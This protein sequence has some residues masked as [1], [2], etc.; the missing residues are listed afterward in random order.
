M[1]IVNICISILFVVL[2]FWQVQVHLPY[3][4]CQ[5]EHTNLFIGDWDA[6]LASL[7]QMG[8]VVKWV[9]T[10]G[11]QFF[12]KPVWGVLMFLLPVWGLF[13]ITACVLR[14]KGKSEGLWIPL[15]AWLAVAQLFSL[16]DFNFYWWG[17]MAL[18]LALGILWVWSF[19]KPTWVRDVLFIV[20]IPFI[21]WWLGSVVLVYVLAGIGLFSQKKRWWQT[22]LLPFMVYV[23]SIALIYW[24]SGCP[25]L[26]AAVSPSMYF[27]ALLDLSFYHLGAWGIAILVWG[28]CRFLPVI[29]KKALVVSIGVIGWALPVYGLLQYG[30]AFRNQS[31]IDLWRLNH[32]AYTENWDGILQFLAGKPMNNYLFMNY[33]NMALAEKGEL[34]NLAFNYS[35]RGMN[36]LMVDANSTGSIRM[37]ASDI[38]YMVGCVAE[39]QQHTFE[40]QVTFPT[41]LGI[42]TMKRLVKTNLIFGHYA[43]AEK[44]LNLISKT[45]FHKEWADR[46]KMFLYNDAA[47]ETDSELGE[48]RKSLSKQN[49][50]SMF[51][52]WQME[53]DDILVANPKNEKAMTYLG[54]SFLLNKD[55][56]GFRHFL[57]KYYGTESLQ[58][59]PVVFQQGVIALF[60]QEKDKW[61]NYHLSPQVVNLY[62]QYRDLYFKNQRQP[63]LKNIMARSFGYTFWYYL[64]FV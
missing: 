25:S 6:F 23:G 32:Y 28:G 1:K 64:M 2:L 38:N 41:S 12:D 47:V 52:G 61:E 58:Q 55:M 18:C 27:E 59:L 56:E 21:A 51:Y 20:V 15:A 30:A 19:L 44:Y 22:I 7:Q 17:A 60:Q 35:P 29:E 49:R 37:L 16:Y 4:L 13:A 5:L 36:A 43:V 14:R 50:F 26:K 45:T 62:S 9:G 24:W 46:Y 63:N 42:Q 54:L 57:D 33:A 11:I 3:Q 10:W 31:N 39:A 34:G 53:L 8:G 40:A 48:K